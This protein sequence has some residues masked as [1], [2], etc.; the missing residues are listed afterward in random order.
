[1]Q[2][3]VAVAREHVSEPGTIGGVEPDA[4]NVHA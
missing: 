1:L 2:E 4:E 3:A